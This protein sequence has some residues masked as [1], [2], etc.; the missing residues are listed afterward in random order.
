MEG[1]NVTTFT[2]ATNVARRSVVFICA[3]GFA[4]GLIL[5]PGVRAQGGPEHW[6]GTWA[7]AVVSSQ[8]TFVLPA[9]LRQQPPPAPNATP[10]PQAA[11]PIQSFS[12]QTIREIVRTTIGGSRARVVLTNAFGS[13]P[14]TIGAAHFAPRA[15]EA[16]IV[17][18]PGRPL[19][20][21]GMTSTTI[22][23]GAVVFSDPIDVRIAPFSDLAIDVFVP[24]DTGGKP[25]TMHSGALQ[26]S[27]VSEP[28]NQTGRTT[29]PVARTTSSWYFVA[30]VEVIAPASV[31]ATVTFG[32]SITDGTASTPNA[33]RRWPDD[34]ARRLAPVS[35]SGMGV[36]NLGIGG[37]RLLSDGLGVSALARFDRDVA[38][39]TGVTHVVVLEGINDIGFAGEDP[40]PT[41]ADLIAA[42]QQLIARA[43]ALRLAIY[44]ATLTPFE[45][46]AYA[47]M[48]GE[49][50]RQEVNKWIR[51][52]GAYDGVIDFDAATRDPRQP[53]RALGAYDPGDH[54][55]FTDAGYQAMADA[56]NLKFFRMPGKA[57]GS[58]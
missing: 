12:N 53:T 29:F 42:H 51:T 1:A 31:G 56:V 45:G 33:N 19:M 28:G 41:A 34:L 43:H 9:S 22:P 4:L 58:R 40:A 13:V 10:R 44:G 8:Q 17:K 48:V 57:S 25:L 49:G 26:T 5:H 14:L 21:G 7:T 55:H 23:A 30:R 46:A 15:E 2:Q 37:N 47:T 50:K 39:Q 32:D 3:L 52:S 20:F 35:G 38:A 27:Y 16:S 18:N 24:G 54:L 6:V 11:P 36:L